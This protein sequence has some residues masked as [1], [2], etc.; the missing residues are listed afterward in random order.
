M[1]PKENFAEVAPKYM[2]LFQKDFNCTK[3]DAAAVFGN[4]GY[5]SLGFTKLQEIRPVVPGSK[6][7]YGWFQWTGPRRRA[8]EAYCKRNGLE[9]SAPDSNYKFLFVE[10]VT[11][12][13]RALPAL[14]AAEGLEAKVK[15]FEEKFERAGV[16]NYPERN[17]WAQFALSLLDGSEVTVPDP[18]PA[19]SKPLW[20]ILIELVLM[21][22]GLKKP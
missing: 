22:I 12:E 9:P 1:T 6:G 2:E 7:G 16:K 17:K 3:L 14:K 20:Q 19:P 5:E 10:L 4:A 8:F 13:K 11:T 21:I 18:V 15:I